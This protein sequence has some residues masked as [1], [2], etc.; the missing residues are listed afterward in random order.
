MN[1]KETMTNIQISRDN[2]SKLTVLG[3]Q[4]AIKRG[5]KVSANDVITF[6]LTLEK[7]KEDEKHTD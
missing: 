5:E 1:K 3:A 7:E 4:L 2:R 6:L